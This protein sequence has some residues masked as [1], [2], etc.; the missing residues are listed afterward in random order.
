VTPRVGSEET[1]H[2]SSPYPASAWGHW[3]K[4]PFVLQ[5]A[6]GPDVKLKTVTR[7][8]APFGGRVDH[9][10]SDRTASMTHF[11]ETMCRSNGPV[12]H[13]VG[14]LPL[15]AR[16]WFAEDG[17]PRV[18]RSSRCMVAPEEPRETARHSAR[19]RFDRGKLDNLASRVSATGT[20]EGAHFVARRL[21]RDMPQHHPS[22]ASGA[23]RA[24]E[25][26]NG[27]SC[28]VAG[29]HQWC[30]PFLPGGSTGT[31]AHRRLPGFGAPVKMARRRGAGL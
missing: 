14:S 3:V 6:R 21:R 31:L 29:R 20:L 1:C 13:Y 17:V 28:N 19:L 30:S 5:A 4:A 23:R 11:P 25:Q 27:C 18:G 7:F 12:M 8:R 15:G 10:P 2:E 22:A 24:D 9:V 16:R 26:A